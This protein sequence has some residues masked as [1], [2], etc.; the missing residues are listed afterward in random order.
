MY[1]VIAFTHNASQNDTALARN[2]LSILKTNTEV[3]NIPQYKVENNVRDNLVVITF[4]K[5]ASTTV[6]QFI[7]E[8][9]IK[10]AR[11]YSLPKYHLFYL[12]L[13]P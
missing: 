1:K 7:E 10:G 3:F 6:K 8:K 12:L 13:S 2:C 11:H 4:G 9:K 5:I